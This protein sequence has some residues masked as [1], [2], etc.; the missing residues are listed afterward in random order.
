MI[1][2]KK[3]TFDRFIYKRNFKRLNHI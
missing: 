3:F 2:D 1:I